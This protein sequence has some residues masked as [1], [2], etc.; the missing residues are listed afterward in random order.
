M[1]QTMRLLACLLVL[2][3]TASCAYGAQKA[4]QLVEAD[5]LKHY[6]AYVMDNETGKWS[7]HAYQ[8]DA[9]LDRFW[10]FGIKNSSFTAVFHLAAEGDMRTGVWT[11]VLRVYAIDGET[12]NARAVSLMVNGQRCDFAAS[13][14]QVRN[15]RYSAECI[16]VPLNAEGLQFVLGMQQAEEAAVRL[17]GDE[18]YT[19]SLNRSA[20]TGRRALEAES[21]SQLTHGVALLN[22]LGVEE[23]RL[24][25]L[26][27]DAWEREYGYR[28][29]V[30]T[31]SVGETLKGA[32]LTDEMG[33]V[34]P[35]ITS[36]AAQAAQNLLAQYG[37]LSGEITRKFD[38][39]AVAAVLRA[40][41]YLGRVPTGCFDEA[42]AQAMAEGRRTETADEMALQQLGSAAQ[43]GLER[44]WFARGVSASANPDTLRSV[45]NADNVFLVADGLINS[46]SA[47]EMHLFVE[48][49]A[50]VVYNGQYAYQAELVCEGSKGTSLD[51]LLLPLAQTRLMIYAEIPAALAADEAAQWSIVLEHG[52]ES[53]AIDLQ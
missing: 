45:A 25:D 47:Q 52:G 23:Y 48:M 18:V 35:D 39:N 24:W 32:A 49:K 27:A 21:L 46:L 20:A 17:I 12:I 34:L 9:L 4:A 50:S 7:V 1:K 8:A 29:A 14:A 42:L 28:P 3:M 37:F 11:P 16:T 33:M 38:E 6:P 30:T 13:S 22:E 36:D 53:L 2:M 43:I 44:Y 5:A 41:K 19:V 10:N 51:T 31:G 26:S 40:Q 15:G